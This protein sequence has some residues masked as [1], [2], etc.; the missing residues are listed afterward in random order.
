MPR[1]ISTNLLLLDLNLPDAD[2]LQL[3]KQLNQQ[4]GAPK[5]L[6]MTSRS[7]VEDRWSGFKYM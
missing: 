2:G 7:E 4:L 5:I 3:A 1:I 6:M